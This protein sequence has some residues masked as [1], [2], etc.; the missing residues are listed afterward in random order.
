ML[1]GKLINHLCASQRD[2][3]CENHPAETKKEQFKQREIQN[4]EWHKEWTQIIFAN[5]SEKSN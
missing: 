3:F 5:G 1:Q 4:Y 2:K